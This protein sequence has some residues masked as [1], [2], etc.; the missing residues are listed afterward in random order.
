MLES[1]TS[2]QVRIGSHRVEISQ[3]LRD[4][5]DLLLV[6]TDDGRRAILGDG[7]AHPE[8]LL[9]GLAPEEHARSAA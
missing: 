8:P 6:E 5:P 4:R 9:D 7:D 1:M 2:K 3:P